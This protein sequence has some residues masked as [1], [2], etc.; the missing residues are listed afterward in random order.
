MMPEKQTIGAREVKESS[1]SISIEALPSNKTMY[2][3]RLNN[4]DD[5]EI[6]PKRCQN[7]REVFDTFKPEVETTVESMEGETVTAKFQ[8]QKMEDFSP[9]KLIEQ[10]DAL[11]EMNLEK[12]LLNDIV[13]Q[14][15]KNVALK[16]GLKDPKKKEEFL[17]LIDS[18]I[19]LLGG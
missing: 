16:K 17:K 19:N 8:F 6:T 14:M 4:E 15:E 10:N 1:D 11:S 13:K 12:E 7:I 18:C 9:K 2:V 3:D 5:P